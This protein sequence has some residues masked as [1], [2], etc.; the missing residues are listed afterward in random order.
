M[1]YLCELNKKVALGRSFLMGWQNLWAITSKAL[2]IIKIVQRYAMAECTKIL[3]DFMFA[4]IKPFFVS[5]FF[6]YTPDLVS[7][8]FNQSS[9]FKI[10]LKFTFYP[11]KKRIISWQ[12]W[13]IKR[14]LFTWQGCYAAGIY[15]INKFICHLTN[16]YQ[17]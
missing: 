9:V 13:C 10:F 4:I 8:D 15:H 12:K 16:W 7:N 5:Q 2:S 3:S 17:L 11:Q 14:L 6:S 1:G